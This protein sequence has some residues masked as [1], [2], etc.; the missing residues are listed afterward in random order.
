MG[1]PRPVE[2]E[3]QPKRALRLPK[4]K[5]PNPLAPLLTLFLV[6]LG[7]LAVYLDVVVIRLAAILIVLV[8]TF[9]AGMMFG[10]A[11][12]AREILLRDRP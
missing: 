11:E 1:V 3:P 2:D 6:L 7:N 5:A 10:R 4:V 8:I 9:A 12:Q